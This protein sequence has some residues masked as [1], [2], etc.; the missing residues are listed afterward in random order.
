MGWLL[1]CCH[2]AFNGLCLYL[3]VQLVGLW[4]VILAFPGHTHLL[5]ANISIGKSGLVALLYMFL[6]LYVALSLYVFVCTFPHGAM[7]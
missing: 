4:C 2:V 6:L 7:G 3:T 1:S 5:F